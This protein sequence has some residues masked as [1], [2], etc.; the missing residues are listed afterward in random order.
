MIINLLVSLYISRQLLIY[1]G[2][3]NFNIFNLL[4]SF[5]S[6]ITFFSL[7]L[8][9]SLQR[10]FVFANKKNN[11]IS[12][13][14]NSGL[15]YTIIIGL[16]IVFL[17]FLGVLLM[18]KFI[19][20][21]PIND[22]IKYKIYFILSLAFLF[23][24]IKIPYLSFCLANNDFDFYSFISILESMLK[25]IG[26]HV[27]INITDWS[28]LTLFIS[29]FSFVS[30]YIF[31]KIKYNIKINFKKCS[32]RYIK[33]FFNYSIQR[34]I[35]L[36]SQ[37]LE[38]EFILIVVNNYFGIIYN[39]AYLIATQVLSAFILLLGNIVLITEPTLTKLYFNKKYSL[40]TKKMTYYS[41][42][43]SVF[44]GFFICMFLI[45]QDYFL[46]IWLKNV[47]LY[48]D[49]LI[50]IF[51]IPL[52]FESS[53]SSL[54]IIILSRL[55]SYKYN[56]TI[57]VFNFI[58]FLLIIIFASIYSNIY[59]LYIKWLA[60]LSI[61]FYRI[62]LVVRLLN[63]FSFDYIKKTLL[64]PIFIFFIAYF[65]NKF[66]YYV[67]NFNI[68]IVKIFIFTCIYFFILFLFFNK[69]EKKYIF[70]FFK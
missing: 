6:I 26:I 45:N 38:R 25:L 5:I 48:T 58:S 24:I 17:L 3:E 13:Y 34:S 9:S 19:Y 49:S 47:P 12:K 22:I 46:N 30:W 63:I 55:D 21:N 16:F 2:F 27:F 50:Y 60:V 67:F 54:W 70:K 40:L 42:W 31:F 8:H 15:S 64:I 32:Y 33:I 52:F 28:F 10:F 57:S 51:L 37:F 56:I 11:L 65:L 61:Y 59:V 69:V 36:I 44:I 18:N 1:L 20:I 68:L 29:F 23:N 35:G 62:F 4:F 41:K 14:F 53:S 39:T 43:S 66:V 7:A